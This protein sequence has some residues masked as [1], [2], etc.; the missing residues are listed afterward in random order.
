MQLKKGKNV[1]K[2][3]NVSFFYLNFVCFLTNSAKY[4]IL[5]PATDK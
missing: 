1:T 5:K 2:V 4:D 3:K